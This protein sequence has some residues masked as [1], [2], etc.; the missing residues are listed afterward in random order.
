MWRPS[1]PS[2]AT[3]SRWTTRSASTA[4]GS[5]SS[6]PST[7]TP[8]STPTWYGPT[9]LCRSTRSSGA[10]STT[11]WR[12]DEGRRRSRRRRQDDP[13]GRHR[14]ETETA[15]PRRPKGRTHQRTAPHRARPDLRQE[16]PQT[17]PDGRLRLDPYSCQQEGETRYSPPVTR[18]QDQASKHHRPLV[19]AQDVERVIGRGSRTAGGVP[20]RPA[21]EETTVTV[22]STYK[23]APTEMVDVGGAKFAYRQLGADTGVPVIFLNHSGAVLDNW[24]PRVVDGIAARHRVITFDNRGVSASDGSTPDS[25]AAMARDAT[26]LI[27]ALGFDQVDLVGFS[28]GGFITQVIAQQEPRLVRKVVLAGTGPAGGEGLDKVTSVTIRD[29]IKGALTFK[30]PKYYLF[31]TR[32][33]NGRTVARQFLERLKERTDNR[34]RSI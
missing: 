4:S 2:R 34:D 6:N 21:R 17:Q 31:F 10:S 32:T 3:P 5:C 14:P 8:R 7:P 16:H 19:R 33:A 12:G 18:T 11:C 13:R 26:T 24:D 29:M 25:V 27:R 30:D 9:A 20:R 1:M 28:L 23:D 15:L 22:S